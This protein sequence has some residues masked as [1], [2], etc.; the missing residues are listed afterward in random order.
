MLSAALFHAAGP[1]RLAGLARCFGAQT[2]KGPVF[3]VLRIVAGGH[4]YPMLWD[5]T[6]AELGLPLRDAKFFTR[7]DFCVPPAAL[8]WRKNALYLRLV[9]ASQL[10]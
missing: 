9:R 5:V 10:V 3:E 6:H 2:Q 7:T 1:A 4:E 8:L